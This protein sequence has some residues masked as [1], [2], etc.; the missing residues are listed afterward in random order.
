M[1]QEHFKKFFSEF[2]GY[3]N[4]E[5]PDWFLGIEEGGGNAI[6]NVNQKIGQF[7]YWANIKDG[8]VDNFEFQSLLDEL[9]LPGSR[10]LD[11]EIPGGPNSQST[12]IHPMKALLYSRNGVWPP[13]N[14]AKY[15][16]ILSLGRQNHINEI[17][18]CWIELF[19]LPNPGTSN[20]AFCERWP[21]WTQEFDEEWRLPNNRQD[22][23]NG[24][25]PFSNESL[26]DFRSSIIREKIKNYKPKN[27]ICY[28]GTNPHYV[29]LIKNI[30]NHL[31]TAAWTTHAVPNTPGT[32]FTIIYKDIN[33]SD[34]STTRIMITRHPSRT[35]HQI[36]WEAVGSLIL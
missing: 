25:Y 22:Y 1:N 10:F 8:L 5:T 4:W 14:L 18:S 23:E 13:S 9:R 15:S 19:P 34:K 7:Y 26:I 6:I 30:A 28:I 21:I 35:N 24:H 27:I 20:E 29:G 36:Y 11:W 32:G 16:Q 12:W 31:N 2:F 17:N 33:W 3:G